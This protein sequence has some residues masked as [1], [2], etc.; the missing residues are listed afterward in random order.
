MK[1][2][3]LLFILICVTLNAQTWQS[4]I[5]YYGEDSSLVYVRD[6][7]LNRIPDFSFAGY[8][9]GDEPI[10]DVPVVRS[11]SP[12]AGDNTTN[13]NNALFELALMPANDDGI[14][15][16]LFLEP[17]VYRVNGTI[18]LQYDGVILR[19]A[20]DGEDSTSNTI[21]KAVG[22][23]PHK[24]TVLIAG[25][26]ANTEWKDEFFGSRS[27][28]ISDTVLIGD[29]WFRVENPDLYTPGDNI[30]I[31]H[32]CTD[33][34]LQA[35]DYGGTHSDEPGAEPVDVPWTVG[36]QPLVF[37]RNIIKISGDTIFVDVPIYNTLIRELSQ[38][39]IY[40]YTRA[41]I[42]RYIGIEDLR[43]DIEYN[44]NEADEN[45]A[46]NAVDMFL[47]EDSWVRNCTFLHFGLSG[48]RTATATRITVENVKA[49]DPI[50]RV[51]GG[52]RYNFQVY[53]AS[54]Q[55]LFLNCYARN[56]RH[57]WISNGTS[58][59]SDIV[60]TGCTSSGAYTSSE[61]HRRWTMG[62]L[63]DNH[64]ELDGPRPGYNPR[65]IGLYNRGYWGTS[66]G[67]AAA[68]S[69]AWNVDVNDGELI[70]QKPP[71]AQNYAI[72]CFGKNVS[73]S[74]Q[75][76]FDE[77]EGYVEGTNTPGLYPQS[78]YFAQL[79]DR[80]K[81][82]ITSVKDKSSDNYLPGQFS[83]SQNYPNP[84][85]PSTTIHYSLPERS[86]VVV[87]VFNALGQLVKTLYNNDQIAGEHYL[88]WNGEDENGS[89]VSSGIYFYS[90][91]TSF[92]SI[93]KKMTLLK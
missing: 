59:N 11:I 23:S 62:I 54:Q 1:K 75:S 55:I 83:V 90:V 4:E 19:G 24:R 56:G 93:T 77:P 17:G 12:V 41:G 88:T 85:N 53:R 64:K 35:I 67:W 52:Q 51:I 16:A 57:H 63:F 60:I 31:Y 21:I 71:T 48:V 76:T 58:W 2:F 9:Y 45:H 84:F 32:P 43:I 34:W 28:I 30:I 50:A 86:K 39:Y 47:I 49:V 27:N 38:S 25:G 20:G 5:V 33:A 29:N 72:G 80:A 82:T 81:V 61:G 89:L 36:S 78:L 37:N 3:E 14:R 68:N 22:D 74:G 44:G 65:L 79:K 40:R 87:R 18:K 69:V 66:H 7:E 26:G 8:K 73:G 10:P 92:G 46:W 13:I 6:A 42:R 15:G 70:C 91:S